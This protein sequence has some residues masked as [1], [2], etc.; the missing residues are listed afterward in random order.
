VSV[1]FLLHARQCRYYSILVL[2]TIVHLWGYVRV[3]R[4]RRHGVA[5]IAIAGAGLAQSFLPQ[6]LAS[7]AACGAHALWLLRDRGAIRRFLAGSAIA[8][9]V[10]L[11]FFLYTASWMRDYNNE[12]HGYDSAARYM[13]NLRSYVLMAHAYGFPFLLGVPLAW[14]AIG[15]RWAAKASAPR[16]GLIALTLACLLALGMAPGPLSFGLS[17]GVALAAAGIGALVLFRQRGTD[18]AATDWR[19]LTGLVLVVSVAASAGL[20]QY[21]F[22]RYLLG[23][24]PLFALW[25]AHV[26]IELTRAKVVPMVALTALVAGTNLISQGPWVGLART[27]GPPEPARSRWFDV[28]LAYGYRPSNIP[29]LS[30]ARFLETEQPSSVSPLFDY[31]GEITHEYVGPVKAVAGVL[32]ARSKP[33]QVLVTTY[34]HFPFLFYTDLLVLKPEEATGPNALPHWFYLHSPRMPRL[35]AELAAALGTIYEPVPVNAKELRWEN[36]PEPYWHFYRTRT[37]GRDVA[38][39]RRKDAAR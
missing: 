38:L 21:P 13:A 31:L 9:A 27:Q 24:L 10:S 23:L 33:G 14:R 37:V 2:F 34:E 1:P 5:L 32:R 35:P 3:V 26:V 29:A 7:T 28:V 36:I 11:P 8:A 12:G 39:F 30:V 25:T 4:G 17:W 16:A 6:L 18:G 22:F 19:T 15:T 20:C